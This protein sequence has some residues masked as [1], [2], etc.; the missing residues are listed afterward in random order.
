MV[1]KNT[2]DTMRTTARKVVTMMGSTG[3]T[4]MGSTTNESVTYQP[5]PHT[6]YVTATD[7]H[8]SVSEDISARVVTKYV[9]TLAALYFLLLWIKGGVC[10]CPRFTFI[11]FNC[12]LHQQTSHY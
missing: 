2:T 5:Q 4:A 8:V 3:A 6:A 11:Y 10:Y 12:C 7:L 9:T 1:T